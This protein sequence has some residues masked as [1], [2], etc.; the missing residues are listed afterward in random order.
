MF[1]IAIK[2][3]HRR[4]RNIRKYADLKCY[5][6]NNIFSQNWNIMNVRVVKANGAKMCHYS[7]AYGA[8]NA[9][10]QIYLYIRTR[11]NFTIFYNM[12]LF[13]DSHLMKS[14]EEKVKFY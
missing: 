9:S 3:Q 12:K 10:F 2:N 13:R 7:D 8:V 5:V 6:T 1:F 14:A 4:C 11:K